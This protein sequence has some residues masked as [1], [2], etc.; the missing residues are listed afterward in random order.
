MGRSPFSSVDFWQSISN[1]A[2]YIITGDTDLLDQEKYK[3]I[4]IIKPTPFIEK[5]KE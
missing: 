1:Y 3:G 2:N 5:I 4:K